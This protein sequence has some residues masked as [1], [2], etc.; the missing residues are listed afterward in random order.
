MK[1]IFNNTFLRAISTLIS[2]SII[3]QIISL[4][5]APIMTRL[6]T[7]EEIGVYTLVLT[8]ITMFGSVICG[9]YDMAIVSERN[10]DNVF[11]LIKLSFFISLVASILI[12]LGY[13][14]FYKIEGISPLTTVIT[15]FILLLSTGIRNI[16]V[17]YNNRKRE[18]SLMT[19][20][21]VIRTLFKDITLVL[22]GLIKA[23]AIGLILSQIIGEILGLNRQAKSLKHQFKKIITTSKDRVIYVSKLHY[24]QP[25]YSVP[26]LFA[27]NFSYASINLFVE[28]LFG[29][30]TLGH[31]YMTYKILGL[32]LSVISGN[33]SKVFFQEA[34]REYDKSDHYSKTFLKTTFILLIIA[35]PM[36]FFMFFLAPS[37]FKFIFGLGWERSGDYV[38][39]L[40][41][42]FAIRFIVTALSPGMMISKKQNLELVINF[43]FIIMS[44]IA[45]ISSKMLSLDIVQFL[46]IISIS[47][48]FIYA[49][50]F[51]IL[52]RNAFKKKGYAKS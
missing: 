43:L 26:A 12:S 6:Y 34:S 15:M 25:L 49:F 33:I 5:V 44:V 31:Y 37:I 47:Y 36:A 35:I 39:I 17:S 13:V 10:E 18:Y 29:L 24:K 1:L 41:P 30:A 48:S 27:N 2:G 20:V 46:T 9:R 21:Y 16:L 42:M 19:S 50:A 51:L 7:T 28:N 40:A 38:K 4:V 23:G 3:A 8:G 11:S 22:L 45:F 14:I 52:I 32:P